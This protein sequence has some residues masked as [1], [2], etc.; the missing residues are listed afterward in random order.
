MSLCFRCLRKKKKKKDILQKGLRE[1]AG[2]H[3]FC[4][5]VNPEGVLLAPGAEPGAG[6]GNKRETHTQK[7]KSIQ[8]EY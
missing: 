5:A 8:W 1:A 6:A 2:T 3:G 7:L 4:V